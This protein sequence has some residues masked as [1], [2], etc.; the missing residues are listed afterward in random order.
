MKRLLISALLGL[1]V[2]GSVVA[3]VSA[4]E[5]PVASRPFVGGTWADLL[6]DHRGR[7]VIVHFWGLTCGP[8]RTEMP[9]WGRL[10]MEQSG[11]AIVFVHAERP[12]ARMAL[13]EDFLSKSGLS[14][15]VS[16]HFAERFLDK[17]RFEID[18]EW[19]GEMPMTLLIDA[20]GEVRRLVGAVDFDEIRRWIADNET[21]QK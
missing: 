5:P 9:E 10:R 17:L 1:A 20:Q 3:P 18:R 21:R 11:A 14:G 15:A 12:P 19:Q 4:K 7:A 6:K 13:V 2:W 16:W 8:C